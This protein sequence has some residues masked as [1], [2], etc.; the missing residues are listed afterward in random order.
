M[1]VCKI[2]FGSR[3][4]DF[5]PCL[6]FTV[7]FCWPAMSWGHDLSWCNHANLPCSTTPSQHIS[8]APPHSPSFFVCVIV[9]HLTA[10]SLITF[11]KSTF[12]QAPPTTTTS[13]FPFDQFP[14][15]SSSLYSSSSSHGHATLLRVLIVVWKIPSWG[16]VWFLKPMAQ[17]CRARKW[18]P[19]LLSEAVPPCWYCFADRK[20]RHVG[21]HRRELAVCSQSLASFSFSS[22]PQYSTWPH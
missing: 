12:L 13:F 6:L 4:N 16:L 5:L 11:R 22:H 14:L 3:V 19:G 17:N 18:K 10:D 8:F 20:E 2:C 1:L 21:T 7:V 9:M 15:L